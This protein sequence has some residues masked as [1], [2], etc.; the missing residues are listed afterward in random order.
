MA[1]CLR[2][3]SHHTPPRVCPSVNCYAPESVCGAEVAE[4]NDIREETDNA[5]DL[6]LRVFTGLMNI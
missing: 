3:C 2:P 4:L 5:R 1:L 6:D